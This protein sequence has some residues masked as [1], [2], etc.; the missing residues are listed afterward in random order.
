MNRHFRLAAAALGISVAIRLLWML[1]SKNGMNLV[2]LHVYVDGAAELPS[3]HLYDF[4]YAV[5]TPD[6][7]LPFTYP[8]FAAIIFFPLHFLPIAVTAVLWLLA[9]VAALYWI[10]RI[11][12]EL[13]IG[14]AALNETRWRTTAVAWTALGMWLEPVR[15]TLDYSQVNLFLALL[16]M[17]AVR[18]TVWWVSGALVGIAAGVKLTPAV[19][20]LY[21]AARRQWL[22]V[23][24]SAAVFFGTVALSYLVVPSETRYYFGTL[25]GD[26]SRIGPVG[27]V[28][29]QSL[30]GAIS[31]ILGHD[32]VSGPIW[33]VAVLVTA[34]LAFLAWRALDRDDRL[35]TLLIVQFFGLMVSPISWS[36]HWVWLIPT[37][38]W[39]LYGPWRAAAGA[40]VLAG[41][42]LLAVGIGVPYLLSFFQHD[43]WTISRPG[44]QAWLAIS[45]PVAVA[46]FYLWVIRTGRVNSARPADRSPVPAPHPA[47]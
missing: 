22:T 14:E 1:L 27:T 40:R 10:I 47:R 17:F 4:T 36:H 46:V 8:P 15:N 18:S 38:L 32:V 12:L 45:G 24:C 23:L 39:L 7:P 33:L 31:R 29:N 34:V 5:D 42:W 2:D 28:W 44:W 35:G 3:G 13:L 41:C 26:A 30:R 37:L 43:I 16:A 19:T 9:G 21:F 25:L 6:F 11:A 20:G